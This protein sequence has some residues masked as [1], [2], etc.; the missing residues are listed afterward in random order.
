MDRVV[1]GALL[2][3]LLVGASLLLAGSAAAAPPDDPDEDVIGWENGFWHNESIQVDQSD[4][5]SDTEKEAYVARTMAR[6]EVLREREFNETV[7]VTV[8][9]RSEYG[10]ATAGN[11]SEDYRAWNNQV[12]E[13]L[14]IVGEDEDIE[15]VLQSTATAATTGAYFFTTA[16]IRIITDTPEAPT[17]GRGTLAH[18]LVHAQQDQYHDLANVTMGA[19]TQDT[20][21]SRRGLFEGEADYIQDLYEARCGVE[22]ECVSS[23]ATDGSGG[24]DLNLGIYFTLFQPYSDGP[25]FVHSIKEDGGWE[26]VDASYAAPPNSTEQVIHHTDEEPV[27]LSVEDEARDGWNPFPGQGRNGTDTAGEASMFSMM[28]YQASEYDA[29]TIA[30]STV[31]DTDVPYDQYNY[32]SAPTAG[33]ANDAILPYQKDTV[34]GPQY[35]YVWVTE[36]DSIGDAREFREAYLAILSAHDARRLGPRTWVIDAGPFADAF[37][38]ERVGTRVTIVNAPTVEHLTDIRPSIPDVDTTPTTITTAGPSTVAEPG[39]PMDPEDTPSDDG[40]LTTAP[41]QP[42]FGPLAAIAGLVGWWAIRSRR[43][44]P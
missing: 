19:E 11:A 35:G 39:S 4:G 12:W 17:I 20:Q 42:G 6:V 10:N 41:S 25:P 14:F 5:L 8:I 40:Q 24:A 32:E 3:G 15:D 36:W 37:R 22:W 29:E 1:R 26:A 2:A 9:P 34:G 31:I 13:A 30:P 7:P 28:W 18:E 33:W 27:P 16:E 38:V 21:L 44:G 43:R 23:P